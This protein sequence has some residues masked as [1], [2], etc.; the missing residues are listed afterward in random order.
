MFGEKKPKTQAPAPK[1]EASKPASRG[2]RHEQAA[3]GLQGR[4]NQAA[5]LR[6]QL[7]NMIATLRSDYAT[8]LGELTRERGEAVA[9][10]NKAEAALKEA[11]TQVDQFT[12]A[13][14][15]LNQ[16]DAN[17]AKLTGASPRPST[18]QIKLPEA[19]KAAVVPVKAPTPTVDKP[20][21]GKTAPHARH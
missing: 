6:K 8:A 21:A 20:G 11:R 4:V 15:K 16:I 18:E 17:I 5:E 1:V 14:N 19:P 3:E 7:D 10:V 13:Q 2:Q 12:I 9:A